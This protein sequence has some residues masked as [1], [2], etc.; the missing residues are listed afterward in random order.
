MN[1]A[2]FE[3]RCRENTARGADMVKKDMY[4]EIVKLKDQG[5]SRLG[6]SQKLK[7]DRKTVRKYWDMSEEEYRVSRSCYLYRDK[8]FEVYRDEIFE[9]YKA[10]EFEKLPMSSVYDYLEEIYGQLPATEKTLRNYIHY[11]HGTNQLEF[12]DRQ[13]CYRQVEEQP[14]G[15][16][17]QIDFGEYTTRSGYKLYIFAAVL[18]ASRYKYVVFQERPFTTAD[19]ID[20]LVA[21]FDFLG[22]MPEEVVIDQDSVLVVSEN[23]GDII[24]TEKFRSFIDEMELMM[25]VCRNA[26]PESKGK[27]ENVIKFVKYNFLASRDFDELD[28][29]NLSLIKWLA[30]RANGKIS[31]ATKR[32]P[33]EMFE[34]EKPHLRALKNSI[35]RKDSLK[36]REER[37][38]DEKSFISVNGSQYSV[39]T[40]YR[41]KVVEIYRTDSELFIF[42]VASGEEICCHSVTP[43]PGQK[44][45]LREHF[46]QYETSANELKQDVLA[47]FPFE[48][49]KRFVE[50]NLKAFPRYVRDQCLVARNHFDEST[51]QAILEEAVKFCLSNDTLSMSDL[52]DTYRFY[53]NWTDEEDPVRENE[54]ESPASLDHTRMRETINVPQRGL[55]EY[56][57]LL[58]DG[59]GGQS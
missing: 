41:N 10:N 4:R 29:A 9:I 43:L 48:S 24:F 31:Q 47:L 3:L 8:D 44:V 59:F 33:I 38:V 5:Y 45:A 42:E 49:W 26:D 15:K 36:G 58:K 14:Y 6:V 54:S 52:F 1:R 22:G 50:Q 23:H 51:D 2:P 55:D 16:Q 30:R 56:A 18:S 27:I 34:E 28:E 25:Y 20:H 19:V 13:R 21:C 39:P 11:L 17:L 12:R 53:M 32:I 46:R 35:F 7:I 57:S 37:R 40:R